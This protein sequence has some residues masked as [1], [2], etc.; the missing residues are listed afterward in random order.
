MAM[1]NSQ[2]VVV[3]Y[4]FIAIDNEQWKYDDICASWKT[5]N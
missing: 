3:I 5:W 4:N 2:R 1:F